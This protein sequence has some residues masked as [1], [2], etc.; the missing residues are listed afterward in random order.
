MA[1]MTVPK[2]SKISPKITPKIKM[3]GMAASAHLTMNTTMEEK[4]MLTS[5]TM[6]D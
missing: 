4:V 6:T 2:I 3:A 5:T 1:L